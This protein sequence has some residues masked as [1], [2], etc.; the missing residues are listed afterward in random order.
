MGIP[1]TS[2]E[3]ILRRIDRLETDYTPLYFRFWPMDGPDNIPF[4]WRDQVR[5]LEHIR[6]LDLDDTL[7]LQP[8]LGY[9]E[10][11][12]VDLVAAGPESGLSIKFYDNATENNLLIKEYH[13]PE[14][15]LRHA[16]KKTADWKDGNDIRLFSDF[17]VSRAVEHI[18]K[19]DGDV[20]RLRYLLADPTEAQLGAFRAESA[21][22]RDASKKWGVALDGAWCALGDALIMLC[23]M[24]R[25]LLAQMDEP[26][27]LASLLDVLLEWELKRV[28]R[29]LDEG[30]EI[31]VHMAWYEG[32][33][34]WTPGNFRKLLKPRIKRLADLTHNRGGRFRYIIT[35]GWL[36]L[37]EDLIEIGVD[38]L[39][40]IDPVQ[41]N[42]RLDD[43]ANRVGNRICLMG[44][45]NSAVMFTQWDEAQ[46]RDAVRQAL[47]V[48]TDKSFILHPVD[49]IFSDLPWDGVSA[50]IDEWKKLSGIL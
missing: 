6:G 50:C 27:F 30:A 37:I 18:I 8:P 21:R 5:R 36:P 17:N 49:A 1:L 32:T 23:G 43:A 46:I 39:T 31:V 33:D 28:S 38:C 2:R 44:G 24:E 22:I 35:K 10:D 25:V 7:L 12:D 40:G 11:Y 26:D 29:V 16:V 4:E 20:N 15:V 47:E 14:G 3:R 13:T 19:D 9:I 45:V 48:F 41:D 34:F 42:I